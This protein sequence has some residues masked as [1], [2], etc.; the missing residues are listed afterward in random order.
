M[1]DDGTEVTATISFGF[2]A[3]WLAGT[4]LYS[5]TLLDFGQKSQTA[6]TG[7]HR[8]CKFES[9]ILTISTSK[10][11]SVLNQAGRAWLVQP[12]YKNKEYWVVAQSRSGFYTR[13]YRAVLELT[14]LQSCETQ[15]LTWQIDFRMTK[16]Q[17]VILSDFTGSK[18]NSPK[19]IASLMCSNCQLVYSHYVCQVLC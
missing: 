3:L 15:R 12:R 9:R 10:V 2:Q 19:T 5:R 18:K 13:C 7:V 8:A 11:P 14:P 4:S 1:E 17:L 16:Q 6:W